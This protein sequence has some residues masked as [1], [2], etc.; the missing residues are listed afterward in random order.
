[1]YKLSMLADDDVYDIA[2]Y[3]IQYFGL[4]QARRYHEE[5]IRI[6]ELLAQNPELGTECHWICQGMR[7]FQYMKHGIY[8]IQQGDDILISRV[9]HQS[10]DID[11]QD[12]PL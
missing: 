5:L 1:M 10:M 11:A 12:F 4:N 9:L 2:R 8:L 3:T 7:R 6:F